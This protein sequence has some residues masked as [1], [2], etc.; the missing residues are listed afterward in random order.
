MLDPPMRSRKSKLDWLRPGGVSAKGEGKNLYSK[1][2]RS[3]SD[4]RDDG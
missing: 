1:I 3:D 4:F 2:P